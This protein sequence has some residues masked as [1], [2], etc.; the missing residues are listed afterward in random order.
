MMEMQP[1]SDRIPISAPNKA[2]IKAD[3]LT[4]AF[5]YSVASLTYVR[6]GLTAAAY[7]MVLPETAKLCPLRA[8]NRRMM[9]NLE[10]REREQAP[11]GRVDPTIGA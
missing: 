2:R 7:N 8:F 11:R 4:P 1:V 10:I 6:D 3:S 5:R 9:T